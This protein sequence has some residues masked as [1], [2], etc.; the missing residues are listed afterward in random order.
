ASEKQRD[1]WIGHLTQAGRVNATTYDGDPDLRALVDVVP[2]GIPGEPPVATAPAMRGVVPGIGADDP[3]ILWAGG[4]Y[5][6]FDPLTLIR[7]VDAL[8]R[9]L[10][11]VRCFFMGMHHPHPEVPEMEMARR[12]RALAEELG[13]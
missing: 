10:P 4:V 6:W 2:F 7:A 11:T 9:D 1:L 12:T 5:N 8:R 13:L 3:I